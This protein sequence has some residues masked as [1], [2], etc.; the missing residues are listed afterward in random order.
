[1]L[2]L[3]IVVDVDFHHDFRAQAR[4]GVFPLGDNDFLVECRVADDVADDVGFY[5]VPNAFA[6]KTMYEPGRRGT[7]IIGQTHRTELH[8]G[9]HGGHRHM[10]VLLDGRVV[11]LKRRAYFLKNTMGVFNDFRD[12][13]DVEI[14]DEG[15]LQVLDYC[16][17][18]ERGGGV[19]AP[20][21]IYPVAR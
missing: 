3:E 8:D 12:A 5:P 6:V 16:V 20:L 18:A 11:I 9:L 19:P 14:E 13:A 15:G 1:M 17:Y 21:N 10:N 2:G 7:D 4:N